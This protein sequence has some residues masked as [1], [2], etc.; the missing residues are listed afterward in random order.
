MLMCFKNLSQLTERARM[1]VEWRK[2]AENYSNFNM[3][4][5]VYDATLYDLILNVNP[6]TIRAVI[7]TL[8]CMAAVCLFF[9][10]SVCSVFIASASIVSISVCKLFHLKYRAEHDGRLKGAPT[11]E[12][13]TGVHAKQRPSKQRCS[14][15]RFQ[16]SGNAK[17]RWSN[18][19]ENGE[20]TGA[21]YLTHIP[22]LI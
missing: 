14:K 15:Q 1:I 5:F 21:E 16:N 22:Y 2:V 19:G 12:D 20:K 8:L 13:P 18:S 17:L 4:F 6:V 7:T 3:S 9:I 11:R 10:Q